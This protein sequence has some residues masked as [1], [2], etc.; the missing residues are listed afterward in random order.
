MQRFSRILLLNVVLLCAVLQVAGQEQQTIRGP[1]VVNRQWPE[2]TT[3]AGWTRDVM[4]IANVENASET[5]QAKVFF[6]WLRLYSRM[7]VGGMIQAYEGDYGREKYVT[8]AHKNLFVYG[9][10]YCDT[11]SRI[12]EA[13]WS[14][15]KNDRSAA[16]RV[17]V[18]HDNGGYHT[19]YRLRLDGNWGA[20]DPRYG[21]YLIES[22][23]ED[24]RILDWAHAGEDENFR[25]NRRF[26][27]RSGPFFEIF[28][29]EWDRALLLKPAFFPSEKSWIEAG[30][31]PEIV[32]SDPQYEAKTQFHDMNFEVPPGFSVERFWDNSARK[33][34]VPGTEAAQREE[35]WRPSGRFYRVTETSLGGNWPQND[36]N[37][38]R[39]KPY[40]EKIPRGEGYAQELEGG[41]TIG[42]SWGRVQGEPDLTPGK[43]FDFYSPYILVDGT[44]S[45]RLRAGS[46]QVRAQRPKPLHAAQPDLWTDWVTIAS[47]PGPF[48]VNLDR[49]NG[50]YGVYRIQIRTS[51]KLDNARIKLHFENGV[52]TLP[53]LFP[54]RN[55][56]R[57]KLL[58]S[59]RLAAGAIRVEYRYRSST[60][61][62]TV[63]LKLRQA[64]FR[65]NQ[66]EFTVD[67]PELIRCQS[68]AVHYER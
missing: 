50:V 3:L 47:K 37:Y 18:M 36:P 52:M 48:E 29:L 62:Q 16:Q 59:S 57:F 38:A 40:L 41:R 8:D 66:A 22:D 24:A 54:G 51:G 15:F 7:A 64:D 44:F 34:Y 35:R 65:N 2:P 45:G 27:H 13:A 61:E 58:D 43:P 56:L 68:V 49:T 30:K 25:K 21:Y 11:T 20:F 26:R 10:G 33:F 14:E 19:M 46:I 31:S 55:A 60:G 4:R 53:R 6:Q 12:A 9:W 23:R 5:T 1:L 17:C 63:S 42:Q 28:G 32:F 67:V 39:A